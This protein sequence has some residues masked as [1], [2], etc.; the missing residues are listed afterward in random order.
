MIRLMPAN[1]SSSPSSSGMET[2]PS[3]MRPRSVF[4]TASGSS[5]T[6]F[7]MKLDHPPLSAAAASHITSKGSTSTGLPV[8]SVTVTPSGVIAT[9]SSWPIASALRVCS[10]NA[11]TS[12]ARKFSP[13]PR[14]ITS[15][16][17]RRAPTTRPGCSSCIASRVKAP[18]RRPTVDRNAATR[19]P[20]FSRYSRP[21]S[22]AATSVSVSLRNVCPSASSSFLSSEK[23][24]MIPLWMTASSSWSARCGWAFASVGPPW[25]AHR[26]CPMPVV[27]SGSG[28]STRSSRST[29]SL[30]AFLR[31]P[32]S[33]S[34]PI[35]ATPAE[36]YP[37]YSSRD[38]PARR[39]AW[40]C[41][42]PTYPTIPHMPS[43]LGRGFGQE[44]EQTTDAAARRP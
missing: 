29:A 21:R 5:D 22:T 25:V 4:A 26:V 44:P 39:M 17:L 31:I 34:A 35:T 6:S 38:N 30:P 24:S 14:P 7:A 13:S 40:L 20:P 37:R 10:T 42:G 19:S 3:W 36:S 32:S 8:K 28:W 11:A 2:A 15:G 23:F 33:P 41:L 18:S 12:D 27:P 43:M 9:I 16:E 1:S